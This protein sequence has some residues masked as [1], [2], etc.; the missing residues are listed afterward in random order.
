MDDIT[1]FNIVANR[2][3]LLQ[4]SLGIIST[5]ELAALEVKRASTI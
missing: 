3:N 5:N 1:L 2:L 4:S